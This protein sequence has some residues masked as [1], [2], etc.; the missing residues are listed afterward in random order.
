MLKDVLV[1]ADGRTDALANSESYKT[2]VEKAGAEAQVVWF[3]DL[4]R[5][6]SVAMSVLR[7][8]DRHRRRGGL[9]RAHAPRAQA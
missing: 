2:I 9:R 3:I 1:N 6:G 7:E 5:A 8:Q 4:V